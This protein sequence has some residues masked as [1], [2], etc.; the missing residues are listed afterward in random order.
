MGTSRRLRERLAALPQLTGV[1]IGG[2]PLIGDSF[3]SPMTA[4]PLNRAALVTYVSD[5]YFETMGIPILRGRGFTRQEADNAAP[6]AVVS[7]STAQHYWPGRDPLH[8]RF[9]LD[10]GPQSKLKDFEVVGIV[11]RHSFQEMLR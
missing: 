4:G 2:W 11:G 1:A 9:S 8:Q 3:F 10:R 6:V 7:E 5:G